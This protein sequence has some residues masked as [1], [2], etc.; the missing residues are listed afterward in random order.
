MRS[1]IRGPRVA[2]V[3][4]LLAAL[5]SLGHAAERKPFD[6]VHVDA[7]LAETQ[8]KVGPANEVNLVWIIPP[9]FWQASMI[10]NPDLTPRAREETAAAVRE[11]FVVAVARAKVSPFGRFEFVGE[12][13]IFDKLRVEYVVDGKTH[14]LPLQRRVEGDVQNIVDGTKPI[15]RAAMGEMGANLQFFVCDNRGGGRFPRFSAY[16]PGQLA[17]TLERAGANNGGTATF[18]FPLDSLHVPREC[19]KCERKAHVSW[20]YC[21]WCGTKHSE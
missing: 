12:D 16:E 10:Q 14:T 17:V 3:A 21:P 15:L 13:D 7:L 6:Q 19:T 8:Q 20:Q 1:I 9:E 18:D 5:T 4:M 2:I 11:H